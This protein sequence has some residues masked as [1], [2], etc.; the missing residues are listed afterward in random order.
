MSKG[1]GDSMAH[2]EP[3]PM[4]E[5]NS[6][7]EVYIPCALSTSALSKQMEGQLVIAVVYD[8]AY[9]T[10]IFRGGC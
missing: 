5:V 8:R 4:I 1:R 3:G 2:P 9:I 6:R 10:V 7:W